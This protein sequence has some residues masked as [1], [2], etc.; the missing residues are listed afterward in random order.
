MLTCLNFSHIQSTLHMM[1]FSYQDFFSIVQKQFLNSLILMHF[2]ASSAFLFHLF[3]ISKMFPSED[4]FQKQ[5]PDNSNFL[6]VPP[7]TWIYN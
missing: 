7:C 2:S 3:Q 5:K 6:G 4:F 1:Q